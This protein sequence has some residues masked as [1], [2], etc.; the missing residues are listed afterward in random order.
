MRSRSTAVGVLL[1]MLATTS[2]FVVT[3]RAQTQAGAAPP[4]ITYA[5]VAPKPTSAPPVAAAA[6]SANPDA[7]VTPSP[8]TTNEP[9]VEGS[10]ARMHDGFYFRAGLGVGAIVGGNVKPPRSTADVSISGAGPAV[11]L[12]VGGTFPGGI[13]VGGGIYGVSIPSPSYSQG[14]ASVDGG[15]AVI[16]SLGPFVDWYLDPAKGFHLQAALGYAVISAAAGTGTPQ[17]PPKD[18][19]GAGYSVLVGLGYEWWVG[20]QLSLGLLARIQHVSGSV[21]ADGD[22]DSTSVEATMPALMATLTYH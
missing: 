15:T 11:E 3:L 4:P 5:S 20:D 8:T 9:P 21:K 6:S 7:P 17:F 14:G 12:A 10:P 16:S 18:Q 13:V 1:S 22:T 19:K 2:S